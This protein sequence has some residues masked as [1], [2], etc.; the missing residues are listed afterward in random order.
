[1]NYKDNIINALTVLRDNAKI[2][3]GIFQVRAYDKVLNNIKNF[4]GSI[5]KYEQIENIEGAGKKIKVKLQ[6]IINTGNFI[7]LFNCFS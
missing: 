5:T 1:M 4:T 6:E 2:E 7:D 3:G